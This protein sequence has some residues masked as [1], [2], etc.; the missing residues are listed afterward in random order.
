MGPETGKTGLGKVRHP[1]KS[2]FTSG[3]SIFPSECCN[4]NV[5]FQCFIAFS[6]SLVIL[7]LIFYPCMHFIIYE[8]TTLSI[9]FVLSVQ[10]VHNLVVLLLQFS[11]IALLSTKWSIVP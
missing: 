1:G 10:V 2:R 3:V 6:I 4:S 7:G 5:V 8:C 11:S 9:A